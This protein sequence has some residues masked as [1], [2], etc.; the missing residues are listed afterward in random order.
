MAA[1][2][3]EFEVGERADAHA[4][5]SAQIVEIQAASLAV[6]ADGL[7][8]GAVEV[9]TVAHKQAPFLPIVA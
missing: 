6:F 5:A 2:V 7:P 9:L 8:N 4:G 3:A 1:D